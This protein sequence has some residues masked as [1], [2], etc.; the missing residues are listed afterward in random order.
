ML[1]R[2]VEQ[3]GQEGFWLLWNNFDSMLK[4][5]LIMNI[6][7]GE[8]KRIWWFLLLQ[9][10]QKSILNGLIPLIHLL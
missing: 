3:S 7:H 8:E 10:L 9:N 5:A 2:P 6:V 4:H 1:E